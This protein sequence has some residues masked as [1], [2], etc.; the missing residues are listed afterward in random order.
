MKSTQWEGEKVEWKESE[1]IFSRCM[2]VTNPWICGRAWS[3]SGSC[4]PQTINRPSSRARLIE[5][6]PSACT[7]LRKACMT[8]SLLRCTCGLVGG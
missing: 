6:F 4:S 3:L 2:S 7:K 5:S 8:N 1:W